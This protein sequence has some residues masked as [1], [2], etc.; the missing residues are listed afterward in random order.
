MASKKKQRKATRQFKK[1][2][3]PGLPNAPHPDGD[4]RHRHGQRLKDALVTK[5]N[6]QRIGLP[7]PVPEEA[8]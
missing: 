3:N 1:Q 6:L 8:E 7:P 4:R 5:Q 2:Q